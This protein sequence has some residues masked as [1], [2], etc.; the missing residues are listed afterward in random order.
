[1]NIFLIIVFVALLIAIVF[2]VIILFKRKSSVKLTTDEFN[3]LTRKYFDRYELRSFLVRGDFNTTYEA[4]DTEKNKTVLIRVLHKKLIYNDNVA[5]QFQFKAEM[6]KYLAERFPGNLFLQNIRFGTT[7]VDDEPRPFIVTD[8]ITGVSLTDVLNKQNRLSANDA[9]K[10]IN[11]IGKAISA[12][13]S[14]RIWIR[15]LAPGNIILSLDD[16]GNLVVTLANIGVPFKNLPS[17]EA[18]QF[19]QGYYS[20]EDKRGE[21]VNEQSDV[22]ALAALTFRM[23]EGYDLSYRNDGEP[24][25]GITSIL[26]NALMADPHKRPSSVENFLKSINSVLTFKSNVKDVRWSVVIPQILKG[27]TTVKVK[28]SG[29]ETI[30]RTT[31]GRGVGIPMSKQTKEK[32]SSSLL[33]GLATA[34]IFWFGKKIESLLS[35]PK[36]AIRVAAISIVALA[37]GLWYFVF[38][39]DKTTISVF[40]EPPGAVVTVNDAPSGKNTPLE[41]FTVDVGKLAIKVQKKDFFSAETSIVTNEGQ[42]TEL[43]F[44][45]KPSGTLSISVMPPDAIVVVNKD[46]IPPFQLASVERSVGKHRILVF[47]PVYGEKTEDIDLRQG[48]NKN[49]RYNLAPSGEA[50]MVER[51]V[52]SSEPSGAAV[53]IGEMEIGK[54]PYRDSLIQPGYHKIK[55]VVGPDYEDYEQVVRI[56]GNKPVTIE[57]KLSPAGFINISSQPGGVPVIMD[58]KE[59]GVTPVTN[60]KVASGR[61][62][63]KMQKDGFKDFDTTLNISQKQ[64]YTI[65][66]N[67]VPMIGKLKLR[68]KPYGS[69]YIDDQLKKSDTDTQLNIEVPSGTRKIKITHPKYG[70]WEKSINIKTEESIEI[71]VDFDKIFTLTITAF[72]DAGSPLRAEIFM[73][74]KSEGKQTPAQIKVRS[75]MHKIEV[76]L[77][78]YTLVD[79]AKMINFEKDFDQP[80]KFTLKKGR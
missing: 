27:H 35:S 79:G 26:E 31:P 3:L 68:A 46:T 42:H 8:F 21:S 9:I 58:G 65:S 66:K 19:K 50:V 20:P 49:L 5:Q 56:I 61:H 78:G 18:V 57:A 34:I 76:R 64:T 2:G 47:H 38:S 33:T 54:T 6:L 15:D 52:V 43:N 10:I 80:L 1:M 70:T 28:S 48:E 44:N 41:K 69:I 74:D 71:L 40:T 13:H 22:Y 60:Q 16:G 67:L 11:Q 23:L 17:D 72:D 14:Q 12:A 55:I 4:F 77:N 63:F 32:V 62:R 24:W 53:F 51:L 73:D 75:G 25:S 59:I 45:L 37:V 36:K 7:Y 30:A 39:P 29:Q